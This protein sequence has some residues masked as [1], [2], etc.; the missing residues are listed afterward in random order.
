MYLTNLALLNF[1]NCQEL[2]FDFSNRVNCFLGKNGGKAKKF[3]DK[4][5]IIASN[6]TARI[7]E[8]HIFL[9]HF[10]LEAV[11]KKLLN[12]DKFKNNAFY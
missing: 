4:S 12:N 1:K 5:L 6:N 7:Q 9:G 10:I 2:S 8:C 11:E 3:A